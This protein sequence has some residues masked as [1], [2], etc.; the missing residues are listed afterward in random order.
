[1]STPVLEADASRKL[2]FPR[3]S[4]DEFLDFDFPE[5]LRVE[6]V[7]GEVIEMGKISE[8][9]DFLTGFLYRILASFIEEKSLGAL[10]HDP[11]NMRLASVDS[12]RCPDLMFLATRNFDRRRA[13]Y[14]DGPADL[15]I[16]VVS[17]GNA[18]TDRGEKY[19]EYEAGG[20]QE[21]WIIDPQRQTAEFYQL[22]ERGI[23][24]A[25]QPVD[26]VYPSRELPGLNLP[27][28]WFWELPRV[29]DAERTLGLRA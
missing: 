18:S 16:E 29:A 11:F 5:G 9:H 6:W 21:Y 12:G 20:V 2:P 1:M 26:G 13:N 25:I 22:D 10:Y 7:S 15:V 17:P 3:M 27:V 24:R 28:D 8:V 4:Y 23:Y 19:Y 14:L